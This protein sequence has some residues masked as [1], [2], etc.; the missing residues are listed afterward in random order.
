MSV[1]LASREIHGA[2]HGEHMATPKKTTEGTWRVQMQVNGQRVGG[3]FPTKREA[4]DW[5]AKTRL[6]NRLK[7]TGMIGTV[8]TVANAM[9]RYA[10]EVTPEKRGWRAEG[11]RLEAIVKHPS[12]PAKVKLSDLTTQHLADWRDAR[13]KQVARGSVLRD[14][15][16]IGHVLEVSRREWGWLPANPMKDVRKPAEPDHRERIITGVEMRKMLKVLG[17]S[18]MKPCRSVKQAVAHCFIAALQTGM[19]AG[20]LTGLEW[21][22][23]REDYCI[24][25]AGRTKTGKGRQVPLTPTARRNIEMM[26]GFDDVKVFG[27]SA[28][29][30]D[31][32]FRK[33]RA[34]AELSGFTFHDTR[35][36]AATRMAQVLHVL[37]LCKVFGWTN[38]TRAL[39]YFNPTGSDIAKRLLAV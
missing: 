35:H 2:V 39:T 26:R 1:S 10:E 8:K 38:T 19:R 22:D 11:I 23:V 32:M 4:D 25:H 6:N 29:T 21:S 18:R 7:A 24:L 28:Q 14:M 16:L 30:L 33:Y 37:D 15:V 27:L 31:A 34:A 12:F 13:L 20:E 5:I 36:T 3:T 17:W 9:Q